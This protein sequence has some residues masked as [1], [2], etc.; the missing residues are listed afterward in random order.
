M[1][2]QRYR[3]KTGRS[4]VRPLRYGGKQRRFRFRRNLPNMKSGKFKR[5]FGWVWQIALVCLLA[6][7]LVWFWG[8][9][10]SNTGNSMQPVLEN[11]DVVLVNRIVYDTS[12]PMRN[13]VIVFKP[14]GNENSAYYIKRVIGLPG[15][16]VQIKDGYVYIDGEELEEVSTVTETKSAGLASE[17]IKLDDDEYFVLGD[18]RSASED[19]RAADVGNVKREDIYGKAWFVVSPFS[20][21]GF[22]RKE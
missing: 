22:L 7:I 4:L 6:F 21:F 15:E 11:G 17:P 1:K 18:N 10:V 19:S 16:T 14:K 8:Q 5:I 13:D 3:K 12:Q 9:R 2:K 20:N